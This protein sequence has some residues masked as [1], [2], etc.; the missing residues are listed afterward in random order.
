MNYSI[1]TDSSMWSTTA[2]KQ[3]LS[4]SYW[5][6][7]RSMDTIEKSLQHAICYGVIDTETN[8]LI[9]LG[10][11][12]TD[13]ATIFWICDIIVD[14]RYRQQGI[15]KKIMSH[16]MNDVGTQDLLGV[17]CTKDAHG[18]YEQYGFKLETQK[19]MVRKRQL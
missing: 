6:S 10:R 4:Q 2:V 16:I 9:G 12:V 14:N 8:T 3:L 1:T 19:A 5:A 7:E 18:L 13:H 11:V 17:L 15:G